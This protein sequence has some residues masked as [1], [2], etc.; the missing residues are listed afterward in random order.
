M[1]DPETWV[2]LYGGVFKTVYVYGLESIHYWRQELGRDDLGY[3]HF[4]E[5]F[6]VE[7]MP[8]DRIHKRAWIGFRNSIVDK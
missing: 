8:D 4:G 5:N 7:A 6:T 1:Y 2:D 3:G